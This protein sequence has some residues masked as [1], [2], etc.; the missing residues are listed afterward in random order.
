MDNTG[1]E[2]HYELTVRYRRP[3]TR[4]EPYSG[5]LAELAMALEEEL[6]LRLQRATVRVP[7]MVIERV[8]RPSA[9]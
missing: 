5:P 3:T 7:V 1:L 4:V 6:G 2:E 9:N 8:E